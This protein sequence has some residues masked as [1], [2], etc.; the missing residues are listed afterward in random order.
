MKNPNA[1]SFINQLRPNSENYLS[2]RRALLSLLQ[3]S[4]EG[5]WP[6]I[7]DTK[8]YPGE[9]NNAVPMI[10][11]VLVRNNDLLPNNQAVIDKTVY[12]ESMVDA[13]KVFQRRHGLAADGVVGRRTLNWLRLAPQVRAVILARS[14][15]RSDF[16]REKL[17]SRYVLVNIPEFQ[18]RVWDGNNQIFSSRVIVGQ[19]K[20]QTPILS[21]EISS[22][23]LNPAWHVPKS[24]LQKDLVP[25]MLKDKDFFDKGQFELVDSQG[26][27]VSP[28]ARITSYNVCY[29]KLLRFFG[30][31]NIEV[32]ILYPEGT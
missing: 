16:P 3:L 22:V 29:T 11:E 10:R 24:I 21:S 23:V 30:L 32:V 25:K 7:P 20:R 13:I 14:I 17:G 4:R 27:T 18:M 12:D 9:Q 1:L 8:I 19:V 15:L 26:E 6:S 31:P 2:S 28:D 5:Q